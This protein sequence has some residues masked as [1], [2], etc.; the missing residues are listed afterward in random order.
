MKIN[1]ILPENEQFLQGWDCIDPKPQALY[2]IGTLPEKRLKTV[3]IVGSRKTSAYG[4]EVT[5][6]LAYDLAKQGIVIV[7]GLALGTD[8]MAHKAALEAGGLTI[9]VLAGGLDKIYPATHQSLAEQIIKQNGTILSEYSAGTPHMQH[10]FLERNRIVSGISDAVIVVEAASRSG[11]LATARWALNQGKIVMAVPGNITNVNSVGCNRLIQQG[12]YVVTCAKD[13]L[14]TL[15]IEEKSQQTSLFAKNKEEKVILD[16]LQR[17]VR[18]GDELRI[19]SQLPP[20]VYNQ[21]LTM[22][23]INGMIRSLE[24]DQWG[25]S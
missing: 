11:T 4:Q 23:E 22:L 25:I 2:S 5:H 12:A 15:G 7:S 10:R 6:K 17:G 3:A 14:D 21:T 16:L 13:V 8:G 18:D 20:E 1:R 19:Q 9:A 24:G